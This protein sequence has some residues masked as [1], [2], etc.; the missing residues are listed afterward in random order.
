MYG[1]F[2]YLLYSSIFIPNAT[3]VCKSTEICPI[4]WDES[5]ESHAHLEVQ[6]KYEDNWTSTNEDGKS[7]LSVIVSENTNTY[8]WIVP[9]YLSQY[10]ESPKRVVLEDLSNSNKYTSDDFTVPGLTLTTNVSTQIYDNAN[11][12]ISWSGN[13]LSPLGLYLLSDSNIIDTLHNTTLQSNSTFLWS[14]PYIPNENL[15][16]MIRTMDNN[17]YDTSNI[18]SILATTTTPTTTLTTTL[19]TTVTTSTPTTTVTTSVLPSGDI[20][21][22]LL[23]IIVIIVVIAIIMLIYGLYPVFCKSINKVHP[24]PTPVRKHGLSNPVYEPGYLNGRPLPPI[25]R[26]ANFVVTQADLDNFNNKRNRGPTPPTPDYNVLDRNNDNYNHLI[27]SEQ[28]I[29]K[30]EFYHDLN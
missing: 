9:H 29:Y 5:I 23:V 30:N 4:Y 13:T 2:N 12:I 7:F 14:A 25:T 6:V 19:T 21:V 28:R 18:F 15:Q 10:W 26:K 11:V 27:R 24:Q 3:T 1:L 16:I 20:S 8:D 22:A 17:T